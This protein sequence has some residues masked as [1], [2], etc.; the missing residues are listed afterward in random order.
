MFPG[1]NRNAKSQQTTMRL[2]AADMSAA[3]ISCRLSCLQGHHNKVRARVPPSE[4]RNQVK[5]PVN[6]QALQL[7]QRKSQGLHL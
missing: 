4:Q 2:C 1:S 5:E 3:G 7:K 6:V